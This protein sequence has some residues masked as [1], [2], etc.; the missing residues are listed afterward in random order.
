MFFRRH[1][2]R[3]KKLAEILRK[4]RKKK[5]FFFQHNK[6]P[7]EQKKGFHLTWDL[8]GRLNQE[9]DQKAS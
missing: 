6:L 1:D 2:P 9:L 5:T 8:K 3:E 7:G 4:K